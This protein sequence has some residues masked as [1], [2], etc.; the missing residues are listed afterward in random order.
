[1][2]HAFYW[3]ALLSTVYIVQFQMSV[4]HIRNETVPKQSN[5][6]LQPNLNYCLRLQRSANCA[7]NIHVNANGSLDK[8]VMRDNLILPIVICKLKLLRSSFVVVVK[9]YTKLDKNK[10]T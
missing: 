10:I 2:F 6:K 5:A 7:V 4:T 3:V 9:S 1:M 8:P